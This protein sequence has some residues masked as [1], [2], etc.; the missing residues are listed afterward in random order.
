M[1]SILNDNNIIFIYQFLISFISSLLIVSFQ[2]KYR[3]FIKINFPGPQK[4]HNNFVPRF[5][6]ISF[7]IS[8][9]FFIYFFDTKYT[10]SFILILISCLPA[11]ISGLC[12]DFTNLIT[13]KARLFA[14]IVSGILFISLFD[15]KITNVGISFIDYSLGLE[16]LSIF[17]T[18]LSIAILIQAYNLIDGLNGLAIINFIGVL[19]A[20]F[21]ISNVVEDQFLL[22]LSLC[23]F[24]GI[25]GVFLLNFP[26][27]KIFL[28]DG[29]AYFIGAISAILVII[30]S[31]KHEEV[32]PAASL[33]IIIYPVYELIRSLVRRSYQNLS[34]VFQ[35]DDKHLHSIVYKKNLNKVNKPTIIVN[36]ISSIQISFISI[37]SSFWSCFFFQNY[38]YIYL[39]III[40]IIMFE[41]MIRKK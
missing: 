29:G 28:G 19:F 8:I 21:F 17:V 30:L 16:Y 5:G 4:I 37:F 31:Q 34:L 32:H 38:V 35:P 7:I 24:F 25:I 41:I 3:T 27:G 40:F 15:M 18:V 23:L 10:N 39:G 26:F 2:N 13:P 6:G 36:S 33:L 11:F 20:V 12:E 1:F 9:I 14:S 22:Q